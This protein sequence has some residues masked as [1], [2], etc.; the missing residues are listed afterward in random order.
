M[1]AAKSLEA[2]YNELLQITQETPASEQQSKLSAFAKQH[3]NTFNF[4][5]Y[6]DLVNKANN[7]KLF[8]QLSQSLAKYHDNYDLQTAAFQSLRVLSRSKV[9]VNVLMTEQFHELMLNALKS[10]RRKLIVQALA[11]M[12]NLC[13]MNK[14]QVTAHAVKFKTYQQIVDIVTSKDDKFRGQDRIYFLGLNC[15]FYLVLDKSIGQDIYNQNAFFQWLF[16]LFL[17]KSK[18]CQRQQFWNRLK[19]EAKTAND[20]KKSEEKEPPQNDDNAASNGKTDEDITYN[21]DEDCRLMVEVLRILF[22]FTL[23][24][25]NVLKFKLDTFEPDYQRKVVG[26]AVELLSLPCEWEPEFSLHCNA[27]LE[28]LC[29]TPGLISIK[30]KICNVALY[31]GD[32]LGMNLSVASAQPL[33]RLMEFYCMQTR[34]K[35][36]TMPQIA[37]MM[38]FLKAVCRYNGKVRDE[39]KKYIFKDD[40]NPT[41]ADSD[42]DDDENDTSSSPQEERDKMMRPKHLDKVKDGEETIKNL[43]IKHCTSVNYS[44]KRTVAEFL[45]ALCGEDQQ[46][47]IRLCGLGNAIGIFVDK[48]IPGFAGAAD[49][50]T[51]LDDVARLRRMKEKQEKQKGKTE[52][53]EAQSD[54]KKSNKKNAGDNNNND[55]GDTGKP[56]SG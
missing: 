2:A 8:T 18:H 38:M 46:E 52:K 36:E 5:P 7:E 20:D 21:T 12:A 16:D 15:L 45:F 44:V 4:Q 53:T 14:E 22:N 13:F 40:A 51:N 29:E 10:L 6:E 27:K 35:Y 3:G 48:G 37:A 42:D 47:M 30:I 54:G 25:T 19:Q 33:C 9:G 50:A 34:H 32:I 11:V 31:D 24:Q 43:L 41:E 49:R 55:N 17:E 56:Q 28:H 1:A 39:I 26:R 23:V